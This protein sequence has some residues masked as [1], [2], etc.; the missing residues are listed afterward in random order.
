[1][2]SII[3]RAQQ[4]IAPFNNSEYFIIPNAESLKNKIELFRAAGIDNF[5][6]VSDFDFTMTRSLVNGFQGKTSVTIAQNTSSSL[7]RQQVI[8]DLINYYTPIEINHQIN[9][10]VKA[11]YMKEWW[12]KSSAIIIQDK[13]D[14]KELEK[15]VDDSNVYLRYGID[16]VMKICE[17]FNVPI[18][19]VSAG[20]GNVID[21]FFRSLGFR[22][23]L[24]IFAN[25]LDLDDEGKL[26]KLSE[27]AIVSVE[28]SKVLQGMKLKSHILLMGDMISDCTIVQE[29]NY[30]E[31]IRIGFVNNPD[32]AN[33]NRYQE[34]FDFLIL[35]DGNMVAVEKILKLILSNHQ[36][37]DEAKNLLLHELNLN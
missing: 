7:E 2:V 25:Y 4:L 13:Y 36:E 5:Q 10:G 21:Y 18:Y 35:N 37:T 16:N 11:Q 17:D 27:P 24:K 23:N 34:N 28:K 32:T 26:T 9:E 14:Q 15:V 3:T 19:F 33:L 12:A 20:L 6:I 30:E 31:I 8:S 22:L 1:M 29:G